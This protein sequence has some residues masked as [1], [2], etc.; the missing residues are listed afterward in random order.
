MN[1]ALLA[2]HEFIDDLVSRRECVLAK[3][4]ANGD[5]W[6]SSSA[7]EKFNTLITELKLEQ[8]EAIAQLLTMAREGGIHDSLVALSERMEMQGLRLIEAGAELP[9]EPYGTE[10]YFDFVARCAGEGWPHEG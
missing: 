3:R 6:P 9:F 7:L 10:I 5:A 4:V 1:S 2:Y 8:R